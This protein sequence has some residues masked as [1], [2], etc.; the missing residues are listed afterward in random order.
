MSGAKSI[1]TKVLRAELARRDREAEVEHVEAQ[2]AWILDKYGVC[3]AEFGVTGHAFVLRLNESFPVG[4]CGEEFCSFEWREIRPI[5]QNPPDWPPMLQAPRD[6][7][8]EVGQEIEITLIC[9]R[10]HETR[11]EETRIYE[12]PHKPLF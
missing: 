8:W 4:P 10:G 5:L 11:H 6:Q 2:R 3:K 7:C 1:P 12:Q 9:P